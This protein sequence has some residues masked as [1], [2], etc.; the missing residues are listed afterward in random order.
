M[1]NIIFI[2]DVLCFLDSLFE[3]KKTMSTIIE[4]FVLSLP[5]NK[6]KFCEDWKRRAAHFLLANNI[7]I[8]E[9]D[10]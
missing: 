2:R 1:A 5:A 3:S 9:I 7:S 6:A 10:N 8:R 4:L